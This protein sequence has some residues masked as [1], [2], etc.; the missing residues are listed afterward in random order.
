[1]FEALIFSILILISGILSMEMGI[2][3]AL[4]ELCTGIA[5]AHFLHPG[6]ISW[7]GFFSTLG[8]TILMFLAGLET[9]LPFFSTA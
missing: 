2:A 1:M 9:D 4:I 7:L 8:S 5:L 3:T 6:N